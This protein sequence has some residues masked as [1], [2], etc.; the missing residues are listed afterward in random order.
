MNYDFL[1]FSPPT[2]SAL[3][4]NFSLIL[5]IF[6]RSISGWR[7]SS[8]AFLCLS[9][10]P[11]TTVLDT[12]SSLSYGF[13]CRFSV[14]SV[15]VS[16]IYVWLNSTRRAIICQHC[17]LTGA[18]DFLISDFIDLGSRSGSS[19]IIPE[20]CLF[21]QATLKK[22]PTK[23]SITN[24]IY[25][26]LE[27]EQ[28]CYKAEGKWGRADQKF[29]SYTYISEYI[30]ICEFTWWSHPSPCNPIYIAIPNIHQES[31]KSRM[32]L[33]NHFFKKLS[34]AILLIFFSINV[35]IELVIVSV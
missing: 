17:L 34:T 9:W 23:Q 12:V 29:L 13:Y 21:R 11:L 6:R 33:K 27:Y 14:S 31:T 10:V 18:E 20:Q 26:I 30:P 25:I 5:K 3:R 19:T 28:L 35:K 1:L 7:S 4:M 32:T 2:P 15:H 16:Q 24:I 8:L 22:M